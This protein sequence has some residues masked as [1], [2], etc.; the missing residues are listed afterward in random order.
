MPVKNGDKVTMHYVGSLD[1]GSE[2]DN[3]YK[4]GEPLEF[5]VGQ[6]QLIQG[7]DSA[8]V[9][10]E[11]G[12]KKTLKI[13]PEQAYGEYQE[14]AQKAVPISA[15]RD[16]EEPQLGGMVGVTMEDGAQ[17][18]A[19]IKAI[20]DEEVTLD[21]NHPLAGKTLHFDIEIVDF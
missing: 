6:G 5:E 15:F 21:F 9:G 11:K 3:S 12:D 4:H 13:L 17:V 19:L 16:S 7:I 2:F 10:M 18:P 1:D 20:T 8:V 14:E